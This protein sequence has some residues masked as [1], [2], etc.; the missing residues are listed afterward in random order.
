MCQ[1][2]ESKANESKWNDDTK[3][4]IGDLEKKINDLVLEN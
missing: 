2:I 3:R 1:E 4:I